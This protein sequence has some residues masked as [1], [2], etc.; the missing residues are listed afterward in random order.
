DRAALALFAPDG[1]PAKRIDL[2][3]A[4]SRTPIYPE[5]LTADVEGGLVVTDRCCSRA[6]LVRTAADGTVR[7]NVTPWFPGRKQEMSPER[8]RVGPDGRLWV[9]DGS[10]V[11]RLDADGVADRLL[12]EPPDRDWLG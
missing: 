3:K 5:D 11:A 12:G 7:E 9:T 4:W 1:T 10:A 2:A 8:V 6:P